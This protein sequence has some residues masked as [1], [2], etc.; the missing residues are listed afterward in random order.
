M[1]KF[2]GFFGSNSKENLSHA[3]HLQSS[4]NP[5]IVI[6]NFTICWRFIQFIHNKPCHIDTSFRLKLYV[7]F[8]SVLSKPAD[9][10][11]AEYNQDRFYLF[12]I[13]SRSSDVLYIVAYSR[14]CY[15]CIGR[16]TKSIKKPNYRFFSVDCKVFE[17]CFLGII[18]SMQP[19]GVN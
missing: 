6:R 10:M 13:L 4:C 18:I 7:F 3:K 8:F 5:H 15:H 11:T 1:N 14:N 12:L 16:I 9:E 17:R 19:L 2:H